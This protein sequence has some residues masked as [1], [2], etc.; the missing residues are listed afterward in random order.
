M[1][2][3]SIKHKYPT[4]QEITPSFYELDKSFKAVT[5]STAKPRIGEKYY[6]AMNDFDG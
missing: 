1:S 5:S 3:V 6:N 2:A 4:K